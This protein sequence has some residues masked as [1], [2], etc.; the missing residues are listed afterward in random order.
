MVL[1]VQRAR[2]GVTFLM[3]IQHHRC[4]A[5]GHRPVHGSGKARTSRGVA[6][7]NEAVQRQHP[8]GKPG[9]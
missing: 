3:A 1:G 4:R 6:G 7:G 8:V 5:T 2:C 9:G